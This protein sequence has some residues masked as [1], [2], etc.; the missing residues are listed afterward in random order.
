MAGKLPEAKKGLG[1]GDYPRVILGIL[2]ILGVILAGYAFYIYKKKTRQNENKFEKG[3]FKQV[4]LLVACV[5]FYIK[6][7]AYLGFII[8]TPFFMFAMMYIFGLRKWIKMAAISIVSTAVIYIIFN[9]FLYVLLP[10][11]NLF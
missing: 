4:F 9:N 1:P 11:F 7:Q 10:R 3:E 8:L 5:A 6:I 2:F